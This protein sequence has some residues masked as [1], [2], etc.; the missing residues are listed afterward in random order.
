[1]F[2]N[3]EFTEFQTRKIKNQIITMTDYFDDNISIKYKIKILF[4]NLKYNS[5]TKVYRI[6]IF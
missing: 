2:C 4:D 3:D 1:M 6:I 5:S